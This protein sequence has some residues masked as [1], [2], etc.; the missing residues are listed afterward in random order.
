VV[1]KQIRS[2]KT[3]P[4]LNSALAAAEVIDLLLVIYPSVRG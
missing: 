3:V 4:R 1:N 2:A